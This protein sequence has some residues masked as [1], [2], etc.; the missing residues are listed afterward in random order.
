M[1][2]VL[3]LASCEPAANIQIQGSLQNSEAAFVYLQRF[4]DRSFRTIDSAK[5]ENGRFGFEAS[6][7]LP[8]IYG[9]T[10]D[11]AKTSLLLFLEEGEIKVELNPEEN[12][13]LEEY[14][15]K[16]DEAMYVMK[17]KAHADDFKRLSK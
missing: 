16:A 3:L 17:Q 1:I 9:L 6:L 13:S 2:G 15:R 8:E 10:T 4:D 14:L 11:T 5:V 12:Y 7:D